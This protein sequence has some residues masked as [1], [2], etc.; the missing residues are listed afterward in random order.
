MRKVELL[1]GERLI[2]GDGTVMHGPGL[3]VVPD[4]IQS[5]Y[6][7]L[8]HGPTLVRAAYDMDRRLIELEA[9]VA[10]LKGRGYL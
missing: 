1:A 10:K 3:V 8:Y 2:L 5:P 9:S 6:S 7:N 4:N